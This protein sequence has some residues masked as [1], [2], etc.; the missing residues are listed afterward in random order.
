MLA[1]G[2]LLPGPTERKL[3]APKTSE[4]FQELYD[5]VRTLEQHEKQYNAASVTVHGEKK[6]E[7]PTQP[8]QTRFA[9]P[10]HSK[11]Q[12]GSNPNAS[13]KMTQNLEQ[14]EA[15]QPL[16]DTVCEL[17]VTG[18]VTKVTLLVIAEILD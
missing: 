10:P 1:Q 5:R 6:S 12:P 14:N 2:S 9:K 18:V 17:T 7:K 15:L 13:R 8:K 4:T 16:E 3:G 11:E